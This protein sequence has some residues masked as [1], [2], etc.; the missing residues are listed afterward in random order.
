MFNECDSLTFD[1]KVTLDRLIY[2]EVIF[3]VCI[4]QPLHSCQIF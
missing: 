3:L 4:Y 1:D 2:R